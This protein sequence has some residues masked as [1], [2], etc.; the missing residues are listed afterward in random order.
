M[1]LDILSFACQ[2]LVQFKTLP[3]LD[4]DLFIK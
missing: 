3:L 4:W 2:Y 1:G